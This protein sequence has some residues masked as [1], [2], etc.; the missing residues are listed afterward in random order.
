MTFLQ[1]LPYFLIGL[2][3]GIVAVF[4]FLDKKNTSF[5]YLPNARVLKNIRV[6]ERIY[7]EE[8][9]KTLFEKEMDTSYISALLFKG[10]VDIR[11]KEKYNTC[12]RYTIKGTDSLNY[13]SVVVLNCE[14]TAT[15]EKISVN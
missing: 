15:I 12:V 7:T 2:F 10:D 4:F 1:R 14:N 6:K 9:L 5:D 13:I 3:L 11:N 8:A